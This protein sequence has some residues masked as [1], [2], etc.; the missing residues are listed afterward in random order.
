M[1]GAFAVDKDA[2][3]DRWI[4]PSEFSNDIIHSATLPEMQVPYLPQ[5]AAITISKG[6][7]ALISKRDA[8]HYFPGLRAC[9]SW[10]KLFGMLPV[11]GRFV[12]SKAFPMG[13]EPSASIAQRVIE[14]ACHAGLPSPHSPRHSGSQ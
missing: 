7:Q 5:L 11:H 8:R 3:E 12:R 13:S 1:G 10:R 2:K 6:A 14:A 4:S 9:D